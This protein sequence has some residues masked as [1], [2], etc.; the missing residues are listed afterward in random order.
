MDLYDESTLQSIEG[1]EATFA[2]AARYRVPQT[3]FLSSRLSLDQAAAQN[4]ADQYG[5]DRGASRI[6]QFIDWMRANVDLRHACAYPFASPK[7]FVIELGNHGHL[8]YGQTRPVRWKTAGSPG[9]K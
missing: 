1:L 3:M 7:R 9:R 4:W 8:H 5:C 2:L 6:P